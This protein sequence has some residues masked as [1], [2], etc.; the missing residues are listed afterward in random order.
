[1]F[2]IGLGYPFGSAGRKAPCLGRR[3]DQFRFQRHLLQ[4]CGEYGFEEP[5]FQA[6][7]S[8]ARTP[9]PLQYP[10]PI[11]LNLRDRYRPAKNAC[12]CFRTNVWEVAVAGARPG[13]MSGLAF[14]D[15]CRK[16]KRLL[17]NAEHS[18]GRGLL[19]ASLT[20]ESVATARQVSYS[21]Q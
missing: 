20:F 17:P 8:A 2:P 3:W 14:R 7:C 10:Q 5:A 18:Q 21:T 4:P 19:T 9:L 11:L 15:R 1:P 6:R 13:Y 16:P 12:L